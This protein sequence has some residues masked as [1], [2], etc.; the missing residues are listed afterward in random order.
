MGDRGEK[1]VESQ[2]ENR[3]KREKHNSQGQRVYEEG[4][5][6]CT[7]IQCFPA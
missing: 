5:Q 3:V 1:Y 6:E 4:R 2:E 7:G